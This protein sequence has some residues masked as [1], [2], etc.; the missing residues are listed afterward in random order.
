[1]SEVKGSPYFALL[2]PQDL[3]DRE[4]VKFL[5]RSW[6]DE[7]GYPEMQSL[8]H[9]AVSAGT[10]EC[11]P[12]RLSCA[13]LHLLCHSQGRE[14]ILCHIYLWAGGWGVEYFLRIKTNL[15]I[16]ALMNLNVKI[17][18]REEGGD[19]ALWRTVDGREKEGLSSCFRGLPPSPPPTPPP[20]WSPRYTVFP[21][22]CNPPPK[23]GFWVRDKMERAWCTLC[24]RV[25]T[26]ENLLE[27]MFKTENIFQV[28]V[29][30][31]FRVV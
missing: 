11:L 15:V 19:W 8:F 6:P 17:P 9:N 18:S 5:L 7:G 31:P 14:V 28:R 10:L 13:F 27:F 26:A 4:G 3:R 20:S 30:I 21:A 24:F 25:M 23:S 22:L 12:L 1:M 29:R 2:H 16:L